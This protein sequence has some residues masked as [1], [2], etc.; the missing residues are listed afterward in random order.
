MF[1]KK[2][3]NYH[4]RIVRQAAQEAINEWCIVFSKGL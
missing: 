2:Y 3:L 4:K 1:M